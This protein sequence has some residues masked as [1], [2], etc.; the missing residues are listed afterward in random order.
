MLGLLLGCAPV[1]VTSRP[2]EPRVLAP[3]PSSMREVA[4]YECDTEACWDARAIAAVERGD[5]D[6]AASLRGLAFVHAPT[7]LRLDAWVEAW[8]ACGATQRARAALELGRPAA[9]SDPAWA[10][11]IERRLAALPPERTGRSILPRPPSEALRAAYLASAADHA[12]EAVIAAAGEQEPHH[13]VRAAELAWARN[14]KSQARRLWAR[15]R[16]AYDDRG[17][18][19]TLAVVQREPNGL[20]LWLGTQIV[21]GE[22]LALRGAQGEGAGML[23][24]LAPDGAERRRLLFGGQLSP[25]MI[26]DD[27][28]I[29]MRN[30]GPG[31]ALYDLA[32]GI[33]L[34]KILES[35]GTFD[36]FVMVGAGE[37]LRVLALED[38]AVTLWDVQGRMLAREEIDEDLDEPALALSPNGELVAIG[39][40]GPE[41]RVLDVRSGARQV[42]TYP[43]PAGAR[44]YLGE[45]DDEPE[46]RAVLA[47]RFTAASDAI[48]VVDSLGEISTW[49]TGG[50]LRRRISG[51]CSPI[52]VLTLRDED[53]RTPVRAAERFRCGQAGSA[54]IGPDGDT[55]AIVGVGGNLRIRDARSG[56]TLATPSM[57]DDIVESLALSPAGE[58]VVIVAGGRLLRWRPGASTLAEIVAEDPWMPMNQ[59]AAIQVEGRRL[60]TTYAR[61]SAPKPRYT[62]IQGR[63]AHWD[64]E[65]GE[66]IVLALAPDEV[67]LA[68][69]DE[70]RR[71]WVRAPEAVLLRDIRTGAEQLRVPVPRAVDNTRVGQSPPGHALLAVAVEGGWDHH[72]VGPDGTQVIR[73]HDLAIRLSP[74]GRRLAVVHQAQPFTVWDVATGAQVRNLG[75]SAAQAEFSADAA[76]V[77]WI[78]RRASEDPRG[79]VRWRR[80]DAPRHY[81]AADETLVL[82]N[83]PHDIAMSADGAE[84]LVAVPRGLI[85]WSP[86]TGQRTDYL[87]GRLTGNFDFRSVDISGSGAT[88]TLVSRNHR[89][90]IVTNDVHL[91]PLAELLPLESGGWIALSRSG[92]VDGSADA[93]D[94]LGA[95]VTRGDDTLRFP[96]RLGWDGARVPG[97][98]ARALA[99]EDVPP[100]GAVRVV[101]RESK[102]SVVDGRETKTRH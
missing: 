59:K 66:P 3:W 81:E 15:A 70:G 96:G 101:P 42:W 16:A 63:V 94:H 47:I 13:L 99:G 2:A 33:P 5:L 80:L 65:T 11:A 93:P 85:R 62:A 52:E 30:E 18:T 45:Y 24:F 12:A 71:A 69:V 19:L 25:V 53:D 91:R 4:A 83:E 41:I 21:H 61:K 84:V 100:P 49:T 23:R 22:E 50:R 56:K 20:P 97:L 32:T 89:V 58:L 39:L 76:V 36:D 1:T 102:L 72:I 67:L 78:S 87:A 86:E 98:V 77:A 14:D 46:P 64:L 48:V 90:E 27:A 74:D 60:T 95:S 57:D 29:L 92:A 35:A 55:V 73:L 88:L 31:L 43:W 37:E 82:T 34:G 79:E 68:V 40:E 28:R 17:A 54:T 6:V 10:A 44:R 9:R 51:S 26:S 38:E 75:T 7:A 8:L